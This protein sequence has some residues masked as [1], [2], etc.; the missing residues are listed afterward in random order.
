MCTVAKSWPEKQYPKQKTARLL[1]TLFNAEEIPG[2]INNKSV[3]YIAVDQQEV[4]KP[5]V[6]KN[7]M[8]EPPFA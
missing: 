2:K 7:K 5:I 6:R 1:E 8:K 3:R 4:N